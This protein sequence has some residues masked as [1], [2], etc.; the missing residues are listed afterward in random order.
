[1]AMP[2][3]GRLSARLDWNVQRLVSPS[4]KLIIL[5]MTLF[6]KRRSIGVQRISRDCWNAEQEPRLGRLEL[7]WKRDAGAPSAGSVDGGEGV[8]AW[9]VRCPPGHV[10]VSLASSVG[11]HRLRAS[12]VG[13]RVR[14][15]GPSCVARG[16]TAP[17]SS[18]RARH[19]GTQRPVAHLG[20]GTHGPAGFT[21]ASP[22]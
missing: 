8:R 13:L 22:D 2:R 5:C 19:D 11:G 12:S 14:R 10:G 18:R 20:P 16:S 7:A 1:M 6:C 21:T 3:S 15:E 9:R 4:R 17:D